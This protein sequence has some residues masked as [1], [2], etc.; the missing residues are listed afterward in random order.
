MQK[1]QMKHNKNSTIL[2]QDYDDIVNK[3]SI[4]I[5]LIHLE[6]KKI[7]NDPKLPQW[8]VNHIFCY[9]NAINL[10]KRKKKTYW[11]LD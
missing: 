8:Q 7:E 11:N 1:Y 4:D 5:G 9:W 10:S 6:E 3:Y 2:Q